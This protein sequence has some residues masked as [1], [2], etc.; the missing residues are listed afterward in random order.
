V[1]K[2]TRAEQ[3]AIIERNRRREGEHQR[4]AAVR[5]WSSFVAWRESKRAKP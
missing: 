5:E 3:L 4:R 2:D 1:V